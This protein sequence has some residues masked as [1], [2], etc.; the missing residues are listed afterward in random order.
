M[1]VHVTRDHICRGDQN[2]LWG[3]P[4]ALALQ[5][6]C[7]WSSLICVISNEATDLD[8]S[9]GRIRNADLPAEAVRFI[10]D[11]DAGRDVS[12]FEFEIA[13]SEWKELKCW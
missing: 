13:V 4:I 12:P 5:E 9:G 7:G 8:D 2:S 1:T 6:T 3:C 11:F 10:K